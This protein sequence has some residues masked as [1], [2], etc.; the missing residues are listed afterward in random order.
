ELWFSDTRGGQRPCQDELRRDRLGRT[1][2][3]GGAT[4]D[5]TRTQNL[6]CSSRS[7]CSPR[8]RQPTRSV[9]G[10]CGSTTATITQSSN[11]SGSMTALRSARKSPEGNPNSC[12]ARPVRPSSS[13]RVHCG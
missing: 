10:C 8:L 13:T 1:Q 7:P 12:N 4:D 9:R 11:A 5:A 3:V 6:T 2:D